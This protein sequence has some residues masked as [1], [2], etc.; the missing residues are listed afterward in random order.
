MVNFV[1]CQWYDQWYHTPIPVYPRIGF[2]LEFTRT[3]LDTKLMLSPSLKTFP[4]HRNCM[5]SA[6]PLENLRN[7]EWKVWLHLAYTLIVGTQGMHLQRET[8]DAEAWSAYLIECCSFLAD[9]LMLIFPFCSRIMQSTFWFVITKRHSGRFLKQHVTGS[10]RKQV[11]LAMQFNMADKVN[12]QTR[13]P[14]RP[15]PP[16]YKN[17]EKKRHPNPDHNSNPWTFLDDRSLTFDMQM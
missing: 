14:N 10:M 1:L 9:F 7:N 13:Q 5:V 6:D 8:N 15:P 16:S 3:L 11:S 2:L 4:I 17:Q 12:F